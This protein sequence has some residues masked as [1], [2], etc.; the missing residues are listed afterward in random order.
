[1]KKLLLFI[2]LIILLIVFRYE[3]IYNLQLLRLKGFNDQER[4]KLWVHRV[5]SIERLNWV[6][7]DFGGVEIDVVFN[8]DMKAFEVYHPPAAP[9]RLF[10]SSFAREMQGTDLKV[11]VDVKG[12]EPENLQAAIRSVIQLK[13]EFSIVN[14]FIFELYDHRFLLAF[15]KAELPVLLNYSASLNSGLRTEPDPT[16]SHAVS[17]DVRY[18]DHLKKNFPT[19]SYY[20]WKLNWDALLDRSPLTALTDDPQVAVVLIN[21]K[22]PHY[23]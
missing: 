13:E 10:L 14:N 2:L 3:V 16:G 8:P 17:E 12:L 7:N 1:M 19:A 22:T 9:S 6:K 18:I 20:I 4:S 15:E 23:Q 11:W 5:N 21:I